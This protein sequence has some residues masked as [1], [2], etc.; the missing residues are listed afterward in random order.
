MIYSEEYMKKKFKEGI[1]VGRGQF[2]W[3]IAS[4]CNPMEPGRALLINNTAEAQLVL[5]KELE[6]RFKKDS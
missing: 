4:A 2:A 1:S 3:E 5:D 6:R